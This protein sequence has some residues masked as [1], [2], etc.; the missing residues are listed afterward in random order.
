MYVS[1]IYIYMFATIDK[2]T[3][4]DCLIMVANGLN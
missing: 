4:S 1:Y 2:I 3:K